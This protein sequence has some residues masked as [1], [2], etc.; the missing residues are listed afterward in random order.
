MLD[1]GD[2]PP[3]IGTDIHYF[4]TDT[5][6]D[7]LHAKTMRVLTS[8]RLA[9][10]DRLNPL[11]SNVLRLL[12]SPQRE[13]YGFSYPDHRGVL[14]AASGDHAARIIA[15][16]GRVT[17]ETV[18]ATRLATSVLDTLPDIYGA[19][20]RPVRVPRQVFESPPTAASV[21]DDE[22]DTADVDYLRAVMGRDRVA[23]HQLYTATRH[24]GERFASSPIT[25][26]D[27]AD[28]AGRVLT[29][30]TGDD[31]IVM[32]TGSP[33]EIVLALNDTHNALR[34]G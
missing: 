20:V 27:L 13:F 23:V 8:A 3:A 16:D 14:V 32:T 18:P 26:L 33:R 15:A 6:R 21:L 29:Y 22:P 4:V 10:H 12:A 31:E 5:E 30:L 19:A 25:A 17:V 24:S 9:R 7:E 34:E 2:P 28:D 1:L 11:W